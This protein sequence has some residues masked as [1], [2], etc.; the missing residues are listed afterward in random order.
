MAV[1]DTNLFAVGSWISTFLPQRGKKPQEL[2]E[3]PRPYPLN[4]SGARGV[5]VIIINREFDFLKDR[6]CADQD[7]D[8][9]CQTLSKLRYRLLVMKNLTAK[10]MRELPNTILKAVC[11]G[12]DSIMIFC[13]S[14]GIRDMM[15]RRELIFGVD[16]NKVKTEGGNTIAGAVDMNTLIRNMLSPSNCPELMGKPKLVVFQACRNNIRNVIRKP[17]EEKAE[18]SVKSAGSLTL[19]ETDDCIVAYATLPGCKAY[20]SRIGSWYIT[21]LCCYMEKLAHKH[22][23]LDILVAVTQKEGVEDKPRNMSDGKGKKIPVR[24]IPNFESRLRMLFFLSEPAR[25]RYI[26]YQ[27]Q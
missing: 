15:R 24:Q 5:A 3:V 13:L 18:M 1:Y 23:L 9:L 27:I 17:D 7:C 11:S 14:H 19:P 10:K 21:N 22:H 6:E 2:K 26:E 8:L 20:H 12:D 16:G 25:R 4:S